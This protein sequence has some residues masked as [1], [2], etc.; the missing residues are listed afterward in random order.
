MDLST[1]QHC[2]EYV[3]KI[4]ELLQQ[5]NL[6]HQNAFAFANAFCKQNAVLRSSPDYLVLLSI[7]WSPNAHIFIPESDR[8]W[9]QTPISNAATPTQLFQALEPE[10]FEAYYRAWSDYRLFRCSIS[11]TSQDFPRRFNAI[12]KL[13]LQQRDL[14]AQYDKWLREYTAQKTHLKSTVN[15]IIASESMD[16]IPDDCVIRLMKIAQE[17]LKNLMVESKNRRKY[18]G[19]YDRISAYIKSAN[20]DFN[21][22]LDDD[23]DEVIADDII[24]SIFE[25]MLKIAKH[26]DAIRPIGPMYLCWMLEYRLLKVTNPQ[27]DDI[28]K[29]NLLLTNSKNEELFPLKIEWHASRPSVSDESRV[30]LFDEI[31]VLWE[32]YI[33]A[34]TAL[35]KFLFEKT[36][37]YYREFLKCDRQLQPAESITHHYVHYDPYVFSSEL[38]QRCLSVFQQM[39]TLHVS[40]FPVR[41]RITDD[42][43][44][45][46]GETTNT[47]IP[48]TLQQLYDQ[49]FKP[50]T[51]ICKSWAN[52]K[53]KI[54]LNSKDFINEVARVLRKKTLL[55]EFTDLM[56]LN[57]IAYGACYRKER[58]EFTEWDQIFYKWLCDIR[59]SMN[60]EWKI[61]PRGYT[62]S[63]D[64]LVDHLYNPLC[65]AD[66]LF[67]LN[68]VV[69]LYSIYAAENIVESLVKISKEAFFYNQYS[70]EQYQQLLDF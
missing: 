69:P 28:D 22:D 18:E 62:G 10:Q 67:I 7:L 29:I 21:D 13:L 53:R 6:P 39:F 47:P 57:P 2:R 65:Q 34:N 41:L 54:T 44:R 46:L 12:R 61:Q 11:S 16:D 30:Y 33:D 26:C 9:F 14:F 59:A 1:Y 27:T 43:L 35:S 60:F 50:V 42:T 51:D 32:E 49:Y 70:E 24:G 25:R 68:T 55:D 17:Y 19:A 23:A 58:S 5:H 37:P 56:F 3:K 45:F 64:A 4:F 48:E 15:K 52:S 66:R 20:T 63:I 36:L 40:D 8:E 38:L 31:C